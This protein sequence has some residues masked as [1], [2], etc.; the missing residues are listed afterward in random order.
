MPLKTGA[1]FISLWEEFE[2]KE[3]EEALFVYQLDKMDPILKA[4]FL[5][6][7]LNRKD[8]FDDFF[9]Y[10]KGRNTFKKGKVKKLFQYI[11]NRKVK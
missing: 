8:L 5:D 7:E 3:T 2:K 11:E 9:S 4:V 10:E 6:L 1:Y